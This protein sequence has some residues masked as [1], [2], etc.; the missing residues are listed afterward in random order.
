M[1]TRLTGHYNTPL[2]TLEKNNRLSTRLTGHYNAPL[3][4][5]E[6][7]HRLSTGLTETLQHAIIYTR[8]EPQMVDTSD[9]DT[10]TRHYIHLRGTT[11]CRH[12]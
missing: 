12:V 2:H 11:E 10:T 7:N 3:H 4:T 6:R 8:E 1:S 9:G 5:L